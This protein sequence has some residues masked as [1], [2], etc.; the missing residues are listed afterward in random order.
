VEQLVIS[1]ASHKLIPGRKDSF[2]YDRDIARSLFR[3]GRWTW[4]SAMA[5]W[6]LD[7]GDRLFFGRVLT[8]EELGVYSIATI[9]PSASIMIVDRLSQRVLQP[10]Y[11]SVIRDEPHLLRQKLFK[12]RLGFSA[13]AHPILWILIIAGGPIV[14]LCYDARYHEAG[15]MSRL[16]A[17]A[18]VATNTVGGAERVFLAEGNSYMHMVMKLISGALFVI[19]LLVGA[20]IGSVRAL[21]VSVLVSRF[22]AYIPL[23]WAL[24]K[25]GVW[26]PALDFGSFAVTGLVALLAHLYDP[27]W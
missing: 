14:D 22:L 8:A 10:F 9:I 23:A 11:A 18:A 26:L 3:F 2:K 5:T 6:L 27:M 20:H 19:S 12:V 21:V 4:V 1:V 24:R 25:R 17:I 16:L 15:W 7:Q 13:V